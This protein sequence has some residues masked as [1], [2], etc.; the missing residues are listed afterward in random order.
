MDPMEL[1]DEEDLIGSIS[2]QSYFI[3]STQVTMLVATI[4]N[5]INYLTSTSLQIFYNVTMMVYLSHQEHLKSLVPSYLFGFFIS[6]P[7]FFALQYIDQRT[8][9]LLFLG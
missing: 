5:N 1:Y 7:F 6:F 9:K 4:I 3:G 2:A 8:A